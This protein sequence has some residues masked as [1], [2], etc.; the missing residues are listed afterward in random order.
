MKPGDTE[1]ETYCYP[2]VL[3]RLRR[4]GQT[5]HAEIIPRR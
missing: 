3:F 2:T 1:R 5:A 4:D